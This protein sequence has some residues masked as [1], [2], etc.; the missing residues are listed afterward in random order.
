MIFALVV[1]PVVSGLLRGAADGVKKYRLGKDLRGNAQRTFAAADF[2]AKDWEALSDKEKAILS[3]GV[4]KA[5]AVTKIAEGIVELPTVTLSSKDWDGLSPASRDLLLRGG[6]A[7]LQR[8][9]RII[10]SIGGA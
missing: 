1:L 4:Q 2:S 10:R 3:R 8:S 9:V 6:A 5:N 7:H